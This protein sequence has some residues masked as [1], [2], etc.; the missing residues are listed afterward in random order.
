MELSDESYIM[1]VNVSQHCKCIMS[2]NCRILLE[3]LLAT[4]MFFAK[5][6]GIKC[7]SDQVQILLKLSVYRFMEC[8]DLFCG[9]ICF[10][11]TYLV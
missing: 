3:F 1:D 11:Y 2:K 10:L 9:F 8:V 4:D 7:W 6:A 5:S